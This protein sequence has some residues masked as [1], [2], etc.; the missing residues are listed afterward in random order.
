VARR[1][2][3]IA[4]FACGKPLATCPTREPTTT[5]TTPPASGRRDHA[6]CPR[7]PKTSDRRQRLAVRRRAVRVAGHL[8]ERHPEGTAHLPSRLGVYKVPA[9][10]LQTD[11][12]KLTLPSERGS[13]KV[14]HAVP[15]IRA[16][17]PP[18]R[19]NGFQR[20]GVVSDAKLPE[21]KVL[22]HTDYYAFG[23]A[24]PGRS[25]GANC[26]RL[27]TYPLRV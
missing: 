9:A 27:Q 2:P 17:Q 10:G 21:A 4:R 18:G 15:G 8:L 24:M 16:G 11:R 14:T 6:L 13:A 25:G 20:A 23:G 22:S 5:N 7:R 1:W 12:D 19:G 3:D 26:P